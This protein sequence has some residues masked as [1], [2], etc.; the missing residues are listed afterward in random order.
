MFIFGGLLKFFGDLMA[1]VGPLAISHIVLYIENCNSTLNGLQNGTTVRE[2]NYINETVYDYLDE[3]RIY[4]STINEFISNGWIMALIVLIAS[5]TQGS[6]SQLST[7]IANM[8]GIQLKTSIQA[9][10]YRKTLFISNSCV[11]NCKKSSI[12]KRDYETIN[13]NINR[14]DGKQTD[15]NSKMM[16]Q[17]KIDENLN[18]SKGPLIDSNDSM[19]QTKSYDAGTITNFMTEDAFNVMQFFWIAHYVWA[20]PLK[21]NKILKC[22]NEFPNVVQHH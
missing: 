6:L 8:I 5:L 18:K 2:I 3:N 22:S 21:V 13:V 14:F 9:L 19:K 20:I 11:N 1:L 16:N 10:V 4:Y 17:N 15:D 7:H 12:D